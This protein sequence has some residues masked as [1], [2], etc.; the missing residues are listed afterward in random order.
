MMAADHGVRKSIR[1][2]HAEGDRGGA[3]RRLR[4]AEQT[5]YPR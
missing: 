5:S 1:V 2:P 4:I 3:L